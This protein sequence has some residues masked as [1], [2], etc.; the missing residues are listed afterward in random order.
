MVFHHPCTVV[1]QTL[2]RLDVITIFVVAECGLGNSFAWNG[3]RP[4]K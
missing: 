3:L 4:S 1:T 2:S